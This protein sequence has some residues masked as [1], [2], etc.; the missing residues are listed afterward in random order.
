MDKLK[1]KNEE[2]NRVIDQQD[3]KIRELKDELRERLSPGDR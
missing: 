2:R 3:K 1:N